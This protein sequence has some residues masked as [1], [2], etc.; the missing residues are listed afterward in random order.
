[1]KFGLF[2][3][4]DSTTTFQAAQTGL[5]GR[6]SDFS[7][8]HPIASV[9]CVSVLAVVLNAY[10]ILFYSKSFVSPSRGTAMV[11]DSWPPLPGMRP[12]A[13][14]F[15]HG[16]DTVATLIWGVPVGFVQSR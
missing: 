15:D 8:R 5:A 6:L 10:P 14:P 2:L 12:V 3:S 7:A 11:Y 1:M 16:S 9:V 13:G 4:R